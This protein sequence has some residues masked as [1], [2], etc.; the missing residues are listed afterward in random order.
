MADK[1]LFNTGNT[2][3][4]VDNLGSIASS[5]SLASQGLSL[6]VETEPNNNFFELLGTSVPID[7][8]APGLN[9]NF[10]PETIADPIYTKSNDT[11]GVIGHIDS[12]FTHFQNA[13]RGILDLRREITPDDGTLIRKIGDYIEAL[14][15]APDA[16]TDELNRFFSDYYDGTSFQMP[17]L[18][19]M[20]NPGDITLVPG[21]GGVDQ[22]EV[23]EN[24]QTALFASGRIVRDDIRVTQQL[25]SVITRYRKF[26]QKKLQHLKD[27]L[28]TTEQDIVDA[29]KNLSNLNRTR[30]ESIS[31]YQVVRHLVT[32]N[33]AKVE[34]QYAERARIL[35]NHQGIYYARVRE[36]PINASPADP[37][38]LRFANPD[39]LVP[40]CPLED[41]DLPEE[42]EPFMESVLDIGM[43]DWRALRP[44][45]RLLPNRRRLSNLLN[46][47]SQRL[48][49][50]MSA[51]FGF[52]NTALA[53]RM[54][55][56]RVQNQAL[57]RDVSRRTFAPTVSLVNNQWSSA[58]LLSLEDLLNGSPHRLRGHA[59]N[60]RNKLDQASH[61]LLRELRQI[62][63]SIRLDWS[64]AAEED[65]LQV[66]SPTHWPGLDRAEADDFNGVRTMIELVQWWFRQL[67]D[68]PHSSSHSAVRNLIR[69]CLM[70][71][72]SDNPEEILH[73]QLKTVPPRFKP[74]EALRLSLNR[75]A[76][77]GT[78]LQLMDNSSRLVGT[79][80]VDDHDDDGAV[81]TIMQLHNV[82]AVPAT[83]FTVTGFALP[84]NL[85]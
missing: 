23:E 64:Q 44:H 84:G 18:A 78:L 32:E 66:E 62:R 61:C 38:E 30:L 12:F 39:D 47:R 8:A 6:Q 43:T 77:P 1:F 51:N 7:K 50:R 3:N 48:N 82:N 9:F 29:Q 63:P 13:R 85:R 26:Q 46:R 55:R 70:I 52:N 2:F 59:E 60:L 25:R 76:L 34:E 45:F 56:L 41:N 21:E 42:L 53:L 75:E 40:G 68:E 31:D 37:L 19:N 5:S 15:A 28:A 22:Q 79:L 69:A 72:A 33:W 16:D 14:Y 81:A 49:Y 27:N 17:N 80:R 83:S 4:S 65:T 71:A 24:E 35:N 67:S 36:T 10:V 58:Q 54:G 20:I 11:F 57:M 74:G 73:G